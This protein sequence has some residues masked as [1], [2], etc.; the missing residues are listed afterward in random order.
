M[1]YGT[2]VGGF[3]IIFFA[4]KI[5]GAKQ[6]FGPWLQEQFKGEGNHN[7]EFKPS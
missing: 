6:G 5:F 4:Y 2:L 1:E 7:A 3:L